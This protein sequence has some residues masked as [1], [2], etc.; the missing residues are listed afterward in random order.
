M[1]PL[2]LYPQE[3]IVIILTNWKKIIRFR[4]VL[5]HGSQSGDSPVENHVSSSA[6]TV[7]RLCN[8]IAIHFCTAESTG[9]YTF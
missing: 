5:I 7:L 4:H 8:F 1:Q 6:I 2:L 9:K 3:P